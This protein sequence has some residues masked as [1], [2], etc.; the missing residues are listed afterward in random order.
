MGLCELVSSVGQLDFVSV[1]PK[2]NDT[3]E[4]LAYALDLYWTLCEGDCEGAA[5]C[6]EVG[7]CVI[8]TAKIEQTLYSPKDSAK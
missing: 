7:V 4:F 8:H 3:V 5:A 6:H 2:S 1:N